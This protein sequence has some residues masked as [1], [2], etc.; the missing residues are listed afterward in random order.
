MSNTGVFATIFSTR[1]ASAAR[2]GSDAVPLMI[3]MD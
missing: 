1:L 2:L 3:V